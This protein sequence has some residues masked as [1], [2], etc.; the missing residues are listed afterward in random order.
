VSTESP[1]S[2]IG[3]CYSKEKEAVGRIHTAWKYIHDV[4]FFAAETT[5]AFGYFSMISP[6]QE[7]DFI[8]RVLQQMLIFATIIFIIILINI[9]L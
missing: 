5:I 3:L 9:V 6:S 1:G 4:L 2:R 8:W 7:D